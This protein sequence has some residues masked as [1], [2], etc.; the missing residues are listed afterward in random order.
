MTDTPKGVKFDI[1]KFTGKKEEAEEF[2]TNLELYFKLNPTRFANNETRVAYALGNI[3]GG[4]RQWKINKVQD[5]GS[6]AKPTIIWDDWNGFKTSFTSNWSEVDSPGTAMN[7]IYALTEKAKRNKISMESYINLF[8]EYVRKAG[9]VTDEAQPNNAAVSLF[10]QGLP[11]KVLDKAMN[12]NPTTLAGWYEVVQRVVNARD[13]TSILANVHRGGGS[14]SKRH[15]PDAMDVDAIM[16]SFLSK[17]EREKHVKEGL[18][19]ICHKAGH[20]SKSCSMRKDKKKSSGGKGKKRFKSRRH[21]RAAHEEGSDVEEEEEDAEEENSQS[22]SIRSLIAK[23]TPEERLDLLAG[24][25]EQD[26]Q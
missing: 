19:F 24:I 16:I 17:E 26:F 2:L 5:L 4:A 14:G 9:I 20:Q 21:I 6:T 15:D 11:F 7:S 10:C 18:C 8:K 13:R 23:M 12:Q 1:K 3:V 25:D 22:T